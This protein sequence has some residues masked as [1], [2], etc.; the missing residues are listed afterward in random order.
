[1]KVGQETLRFDAVTRPI[2]E[3]EIHSYLVHEDGFLR[4]PVLVLGGLLVRG[5]T[6]ELY[7]EALAEPAR[8]AED[9]I[10]KET[11]RS[12]YIDL[13]QIPWE[14]TKYP[15]VET[16]TLYHEPSGRQT[17]LTRMAPG[18]RLPSHR[19]VGVEQSFV[20]EGTLVDEDG[21]CTAGNFV[22]RR[23]GSVHTAWTPD[24]C[25]VLAIFEQPN[26]FLA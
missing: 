1:M 3:A 24:G 2:T 21:V 7:R 14:L 20:L 10:A 17:V 8:G 12:V 23:S 22:W 5:Y 26:E 19:H 25:V 13:S 16:K 15:G 4:V 11:Q 18:A 6:E 9:V